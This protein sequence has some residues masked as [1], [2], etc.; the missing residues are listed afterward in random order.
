MTHSDS[1]AAD[2]KFVTNA[3]AAFVQIAAV[4]VLLYWC[5][6]IIS[7]FVTVVIWAVII[8]VALYP[9]HVSLTDRLGGREKL[10]ATIL[11]L[12]GLLIIA[13]PSFM[14]AESTIGSLHGI[15]AQLEDG[16]AQVPPPADK[17]A[18]WP[19]IGNQ[20][21]E[22]WSAAATNLEAT[23]NQFRPQ[24]RAAGQQ[25]LAFA[26]HTV[27]AALLF[28]VSIIIAGVLF[29]TASGSYAATRKVMSNLVG[30]ERGPS[31]TDLSILTIRSVAKG[32][33]GIAIVQAT[34]SAIGLLIAGVPAAGLLA[35]VVLILAIIQLPPLIVLGPVAVWYFS[36]AE[37]GPAIIF[38]IYSIIVSVSDAFLKPLF[39]GRGVE[40]PMLV[41]LLGAIGGAIAEGIP[42]LFV[43]AVILAV[44]YEIFVAWLAP[45]ADPQ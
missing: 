43:G 14:L 12:A 5:F 41:I 30:S 27:A 23:V 4:A 9:A 33:I 44:G 34:L 29:T 40:V 26:A 19:L 36:V 31:L 37:P 38:L 11:V 3:T 42:G 28:A 16:T 24:I 21:H 7:P 35:G 6:T 8:S 22:V 2:P 1:T 13:L 20:V 45:A 32:V 39:L 10:S 18:D 17:V 25:A 15:S